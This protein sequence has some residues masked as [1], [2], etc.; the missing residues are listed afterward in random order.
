MLTGVIRS[1]TFV[2][3]QLSCQPSIVNMFLF[4]SL[5]A[6]TAGNQL[7]P[8]ERTTKAKT[9]FVFHGYEMRKDRIIAEGRTQVWRCVR[10]S[11]AGRAHSEVGTTDLVE[12]TKHNHLADP[13]S[14]TRRQSQEHLKDMAKHQPEASPRNLIGTSREGLTDEQLVHM[15][16]YKA[17]QMK[18]E[19]QRLIPGRDQVNAVNP[20]EIVI[21]GQFA[22]DKRG[23]QFL[24]WDSR[25]HELEE[26]IFFIFASEKG[27]EWLR[28]FSHWAGDGT[29][30]SL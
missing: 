7:G 8:A 1:C 20:L 12:T 23:N 6:V 25:E 14:T 21:D 9:L 17:A 5:F 2:R 10:K 26:P 13:D 19:R 4:R 15:P 29:F 30:K 16:S 28:V 24:M 27:L 22:I 11:C 3:H 18:I